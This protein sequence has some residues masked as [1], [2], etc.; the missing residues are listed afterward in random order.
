[1]EEKKEKIPKL[2]EVMASTE[3][4]DPKVIIFNALTAL[5][6]PKIKSATLKKILKI[7]DFFI[8]NRDREYTKK[9][10]VEKTGVPKNFIYNHIDKFAEAGII[11][12]TRKIGNAWLYSLNKDLEEI[13]VLI[14][15]IER[16]KEG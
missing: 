15:M 1:M 2:F 14:D 9:E 8:E 16:K 3:T 4:N 11:C 10:I 13:Q 5:T 6:F 7:L 12:K